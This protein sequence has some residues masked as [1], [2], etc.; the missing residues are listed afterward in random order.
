MKPR[1]V[2]THPGVIAANCLEP[3]WAEYFTVEPWDA[4]RTYDQHCVFWQVFDDFPAPESWPGPV[5]VENFDVPVDIATHKQN[6]RLL[7]STPDWIWIWSA[8]TWKWMGHGDF[9]AE[10]GGDQL[11]LTMM[12]RAKPHRT[13]LFNALGPWRDQSYISYVDKNVRI[14][15][16]STYDHQSWNMT[17]VPDWYNRT[18]FSMVSETTVDN[19]RFISEKSYKPIAYGHPFVIYGSP[20][21]LQHLRTQ[22]F[23]TFDHLI[24]ETYDLEVLP[25]PRLDLIIHT[26]LE[27]Y[28]QWAKEKT[29]FQDSE[30][31]RR[32]AHNRELFYNTT[33]IK[34]KL[35]TGVIEPVMEFI[36]A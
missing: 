8:M 28:T 2:Y 35:Y 13:Q 5:V 9:I 10:P 21:T 25:G 23:E 12:N 7:L 32:I 20:G 34:N 18:L 30:S 16:D 14:P 26:I 4:T 6:N 31:L 17:L 29:L 11:L 3:L 27:L 15:G 19:N 36:N 33:V 22:G 1:I 24:R